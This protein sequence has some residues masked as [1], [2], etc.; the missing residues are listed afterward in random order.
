MA[1][2]SFV[3]S[4]FSIRISEDTGKNFRRTLIIGL[5]LL[6]V[7]VFTWF[8]LLPSVVV[9]FWGRELSREYS[10]ETRSEVVEA[11]RDEDYIN[12]A[13]LLRSYK[14]NSEGG[15][16]DQKDYVETVLRIRMD[17]LASETPLDKRLKWIPFDLKHPDKIIFGLFAPDGSSW[18]L[19]AQGL[20]HEMER[21]AQELAF[22]HSC[23]DENPMDEMGK[24][25]LGIYEGKL[26]TAAG[27]QSVSLT[28]D[29]LDWIKSRADELRQDSDGQSAENES[30]DKS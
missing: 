26:E 22:L 12:A 1:V 17:L 30:P 4:F 9:Y 20:P 21:V 19:N 18:R 2:P 10:E 15:R 6:V 13:Y 24:S 8:I 23:C 14:M 7:V 29:E 27:W 16:D 3:K 25:M 5:L 28:E 11:F